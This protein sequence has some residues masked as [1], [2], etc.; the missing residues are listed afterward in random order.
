MMFLNNRNFIKGIIIKKIRY[1][2]YHEILHILT[3]QG[4]I[5]SFFYENVYKSKK[6]LK[7]SSPYE[8]SVNYFPTNGMNKITNLEIENPYSNIVYDV[9][10]NSYISNLLEFVYYIA[11]NAPVSYKLLKRSLEL[12]EEGTSE[13]LVC[14]YFLLYILKNQGFLFKYQKTDYDYVGYSFLK[15]SFV[16][17]FNIDE[18]IYGINNNLVKL[19]YYLSIHNIEFLQNLDISNSDLVKLF[20]FFNIL[21]K[22][23]VGIVAKSYKKILELEEL[24]GSNKKEDFNE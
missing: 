11:F 21:L 2:D 8:V 14:S 6:K 20:S 3:E 19:I 12:V 18:S 15:N 22:E 1:K 17:R 4:N 13:K 10:K 23:Y 5:E 9:L 7:V 24:L 16:D